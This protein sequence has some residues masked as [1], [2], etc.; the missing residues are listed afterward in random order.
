MHV[1]LI[2][3]RQRRQYHHVYSHA[4]DLHKSEDR[5]VNV[6][7]RD[8]RHICPVVLDEARG[9]N[10]PGVVVVDEAVGWERGERVYTSASEV[11]VDCEYSR[12]LGILHSMMQYS[13]APK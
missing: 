9:V 7:A 6:A 5:V 2:S 12:W 11:L 8:T 3:R 1:S 13:R 4:T 10:A